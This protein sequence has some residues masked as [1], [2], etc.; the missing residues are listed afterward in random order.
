M[1]IAAIFPHPQA[2]E[3][4]WRPI[5]SGL[6]PMKGVRMSVLL[7]MW[8]L[9]LLCRRHSSLAN[10]WKCIKM[11]PMMT[12]SNV[13]KQCKLDELL[14]F[15]CLLQIYEILLPRSIGAC[16]ERLIPS[17]I[18]LLSSSA[19]GVF[20]FF[21]VSPPITWVVN[22]SSASKSVAKTHCCWGPY[23]DCGT[24]WP[25]PQGWLVFWPGFE[26]PLSLVLTS[27]VLAGLFKTWSCL[28]LEG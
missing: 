17:K 28:L 22:W 8:C 4:F 9:L 25:Q 24:V 20:H 19:N 15:L 11:V 1:P 13:Q 27:M 12:E 3:D 5:A 18:W 16:K 21:G 6:W 7:S 10:F 2:D 26:K 23:L 14:N